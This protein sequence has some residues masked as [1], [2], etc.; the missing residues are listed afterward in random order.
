MPETPIYAVD[1]KRDATR[2]ASKLKTVTQHM[3]ERD[4]SDRVVQALCE[5]YERVMQVKEDCTFA[6][7]ERLCAVEEVRRVRKAAYVL[8]G[9]RVI[10]QA[11]EDDY[12]FKA[13]CEQLW[14][15]ACAEESTAEFAV[16]E[17]VAPRKL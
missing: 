16:G 12:A 7:R 3:S 5:E 17:V 4:A 11:S 9:Q 15:M 6:L 1:V 14:R 13:E 2:L 8:M 10:A